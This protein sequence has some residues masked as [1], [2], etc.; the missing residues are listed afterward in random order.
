M[1]YEQAI[2]WI[3]SRQWSGTG[4]GIVRSGKLLALLENPHK[5]LKFIHVAGTNGKGSVSACL[6]KILTVAGYRTGLYVSPHLVRFND[7]IMYNGEEIGDGDFARIAGQVRE[8][9]EKM[10]DAPTVFE[11]MTAMG[12]LYFLEKAC[13]VV[14]LEVGMGGRLD[15]TNVIDAPELSVITSIGLDHTK[16][17]GDTL[18]KIAFEKGGIIKEGCPVVI[19]G[20]NKA[21]LPVLED[22]CRTKNAPLTVSRPEKIVRRAL[23]FGREMFSYGGFED[24]ALSL[25]GVYQV[26]NAAVV[27]EAVR[28]LQEK[29]W[30]ISSKDARTGMEQVYWPGRFEIIHKEPVFILDGSHNPDGVR[31][32]K[33]SL[34]CYFPDQKVRFLIGMLSTKDVEEMVRLIEPM[35]QEIAVVMPPSDKAVDSSRMSEM[36]RRESSVKVRAF[37][38]I[39]AGVEYLLSTAQPSDVIC[40][41]GS[42]YSIDEIRSCAEKVWK[43]GKMQE[44]P[45][46][47]S[48]SRPEGVR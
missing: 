13:D 44:C 48:E 4:K 26:K 45:E 42:L 33:E 9:A 28:I 25:P 8:A 14:V 41:T 18:E 46:S 19:D 6:S 7:R 24:V 12:M 39:G 29:G 27:V 15:S 34:C 16:E 31:A 3:D 11:I 1:T 30:N 5:K 40:A 37:E 22:I 2:S 43:R 32:T 17:L 10:E 20:S 47:V 36:I 38:S 21:V 23:G 35:A